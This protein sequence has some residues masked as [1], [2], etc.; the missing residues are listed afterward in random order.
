MRHFILV[1]LLL[2]FAPVLAQTP[3]VP[4]P[5]AKAVSDFAEL[6][7]DSEEKA[8]SDSL[9]AFYQ[10]STHQIAVVTVPVAWQGNSSIKE[11]A[12]SLAS[13]W[14]LGLQGK[15]NGVLLLIVGKK[16]DKKGRGVRI[17]VGY[18][19]EGNLPDTKCKEILDNQIIP[20]FKQGQYATGI[21]QGIVAIQQAI[22]HTEI[23][24]S[25]STS[26]PTPASVSSTE[27][28]YNSLFNWELVLA[29]VLFVV[30]L[31]LW[32]QETYKIARYLIFTYLTGFVVMAF[33]NTHLISDG[34]VGALFVFAFI[35]IIYALVV[36]FALFSNGKTYSSSSSSSHSN[37]SYSSYTDYSSSSYSDS[38][39]S[40]SDDSSSSSSDYSGGGGDF[41]GGG[42]DSSW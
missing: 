42:A 10:A 13:S 16:E 1:L 12:Y 14:K 30:H 25:S 23:T 32:A 18:G 4:A 27:Q 21:Q 39:S 37:S 15:D 31:I 20:S 8:M 26:S 2:S 3:N 29:F 5:T 7:S 28:P 6:L 35:W 40:S 22:Q 17:E 11:Y 24:S 41:G 9:M 38:S 36:F 33:M 34:Q 19:L